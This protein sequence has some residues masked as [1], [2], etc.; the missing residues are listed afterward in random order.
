M[1]TR[2][3]F[4]PKKVLF[5]LLLFV[6]LG[7]SNIAEGKINSY[8]STKKEVFSTSNNQK[9]RN[10][11]ISITADPVFEAYFDDPLWIAEELYGTAVSSPTLADLDRD[12]DLEIIILTENDLIYILDHT[13]API[14][15]WGNPFPKGIDESLVSV[16]GFAPHPIA[17]DL[18]DDD[19]LEIICPAFDGI[20]Y[21]WFLNGSEVPGWPVTVGGN[22]ISSIAVGDIDG[23]MEEELVIGSWDNKLYA[24]EKNGSTVTGFPFEGATDQIFSTPA[25]GNLDEDH[26]LEIVFGSYDNAI[27]ALKGNGSLL[28]GWPQ[29][30]GNYVRAS[31]AIVDLDNDS[32]N[33]IIIGSW[34]KNLYIFHSN[35][36]PFSAWPW[37]SGSS[38][39]NSAT[40]EDLDGDGYKDFLIQPSNITLYAFIESRD[41]TN[42][43]WEL[44]YLEA[45]NR[46]VLTAD[47]N[48]DYIPEVIGVTSTGKVRVINNNG[49]ELTTTLISEKGINSAP[50]VGDID[51]DGVIEILFTTIGVGADRQF[52]DV[53]AF[54]LDA[55]GLLPWP[56]YRGGKERVGWASDDDQD[57]LSN[58]EEEMLGTNKTKKDTDEDGI[59]DGDEIYRYQLDPTTNDYTA[60][61]DEDGLTNIDEVDVYGTNP[62]KSDTDGDTLSDGA[63]IT[64]HGTNPLLKDTDD[65]FLPDD[66]EVTYNNTN[67]IVA[68]TYGDL[69]NDNLTNIDEY[70][71]KTNPDIPD[72]D[73]DGL[74]DGDEVYRYFTQ[75]LVADA[76]ADYDKDGLTNVAEVDIYGTNPNLADTDGD[77]WTD[78]EEVRRGTNPLDPNSTPFPLWAIA[79]IVAGSL[80]VVGGSSYLVI[81]YVVRK[82]RK[83]L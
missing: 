55:F 15:N 77:G 83:E 22:L 36:T 74:L 78:G 59:N 21:A 13:G 67:P 66:F 58:M 82:R 64:I 18:D 63:E 17:T 41:S 26:A 70:I 37:D 12:G 69:D 7:C 23:D 2:K 46:D 25:L 30:T 42:R 47:L 76:N 52:S 56:C 68:D 19:K 34:D 28:A 71:Y 29:M 32:T 49:T 44:S 5:T 20:I 9:E 60:D 48:G 3:N 33:E 81:K 38:I 43:E 40:I 39:L 31:P 53:L 54:K 8:Q 16:S 11:P 75:P 50:V 6:I 72:T 79:P 45:I 62:I 80:V 4:F 14:E 1:H 27:Y 73:G 57:G 51:G 24:F 61:T 35:G 65:D 10:K